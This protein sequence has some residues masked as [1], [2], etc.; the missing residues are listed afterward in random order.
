VSAGA[1][2]CLLV[3]LAALL[4]AWR[5]RT[6]RPVSGSAS[7]SSHHHSR[8]RWGALL[9]VFAVFAGSALVGSPAMAQTFDCKQSPEPDR[10]GTGLVGSIDP[11]RPDGGEPGSVY[12]EVGYAGMTWHNYDLGCAGGVLNP[13]T[14]TDTWLG[15][16]T[17]NVAKFAVGGVNWAHYL[18][19]DGGTL[20]DPLDNV[21][22][23][24][25]QAMPRTSPPSTGRRRRTACCST[26]SRR[27]SRAS[28]R[29][30]A[31]ATRTRCPRC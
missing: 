17:F 27:C 14:T 6:T 16:Q 1:L 10:P 11:P 13:A 19:S 24:A 23:Q 5:K 28:S 26:A 7:Q 3:L 31:W 18:I 9:L 22:T 8:G 25:T 29:R 2:A 15:N 30:S 20:L 4:V 12:R 21:I